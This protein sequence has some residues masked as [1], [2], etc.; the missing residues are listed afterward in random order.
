MKNI[1]QEDVKK[2]WSENPIGST[3]T[4]LVP[5]TAEFFKYYDEL[6]ESSE[7]P[8]FLNK[9]HRFSDFAG[10]KVLDIGCG[11]GYIL[12]RYARAGADC[13]GVDITE[14]AVKISLSR[15]KMERLKGDFQTASAEALPFEDN[16]FDLVCSMGVLHHTPDTQKAI[17]EIYRILKPGGGVILMFYHKNSAQCRL[18][19]P[20]QAVFKK[21]PVRQLL[22]ETDGIGNPLGKSYSKSE[23]KKMMRNFNQIKIKVDFLRACH[24]PLIWRFTPDEMLKP[25]AGWLGFYLYVTG[26]K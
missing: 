15:F 12:S 22:N 26:S 9:L 17:N 2:F 18:L 24:F 21:K 13:Y 3:A 5:G 25:L 10:K 6:R 1:T 14:E 20:I 16:T 19:F 8:E 23:I 7:S 11:N 4:D